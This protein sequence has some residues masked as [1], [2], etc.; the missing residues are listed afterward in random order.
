MGKL[1]IRFTKLLWRARYGTRQ[2]SFRG[3]KK[4]GPGN[5]A[6]FTQKLSLCIVPRGS[7]SPPVAVEHPKC[8]SSDL[9]VLSMESAHQFPRFSKI[10]EIHYFFMLITW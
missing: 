7:H 8:S 9:N 1:I 4:V 6:K 2:L 3:V 5:I 10:Q